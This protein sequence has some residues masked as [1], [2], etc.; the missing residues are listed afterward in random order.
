MR[1]YTLTYGSFEGVELID[2]FDTH[3]AAVEFA[4]N[5]GYQPFDGAGGYTIGEVEVKTASD[6]HSKKV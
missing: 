3:E 4:L 1:V 2:I 5:N 6:N